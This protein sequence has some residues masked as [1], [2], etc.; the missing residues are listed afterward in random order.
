M[1]ASIKLFKDYT[2]WTMCELALKLARAEQT[3]KAEELETP[4]P[5]GM[6][7]DIIIFM[8]TILPRREYYLSCLVYCFYSN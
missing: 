1:Q 2:E 6:F 7:P 8:P 4:D 3:T 5:I